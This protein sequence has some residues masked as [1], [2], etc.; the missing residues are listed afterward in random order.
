MNLLETISAVTPVIAALEKSCVSEKQ[1]H[2]ILGL[3]RS[4]KLNESYLNE[5]AKD[6][7]L[8]DLLNEIRQKV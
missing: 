4:H 1:M 7:D 2:D 5:W 6:L 8:I 3:L